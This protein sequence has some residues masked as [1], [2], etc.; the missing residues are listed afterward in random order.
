MNNSLAAEIRQDHGKG[1]ARKL[2]ATGKAPAVLYAEG[3]PAT[4]LT[5]DP[6]ALYEIFRKSGNANTIVALD[7]DGTT[8]EALVKDTQRHPVSRDILH[9][10]FLAVSD[11][12]KVEVVVP[13]NGVGRPAGALL[14]G[15]LR[16]IRRSLKVRCVPS[17]IPESFDIDIS[18]MH[19]GD[20]VKASEV[21]CPDGVELVLK[22]DFNV[23]TVY[24]K[25]KVE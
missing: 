8:T 5:I 17:K 18:P 19:I 22:Q 6:V 13:V 25:K 11:D 15:R 21:V 23:L 16:L 1:N 9:V 14:G 10:D 2:R 12:R 3:K 24:G 4:S 7:V 20:M